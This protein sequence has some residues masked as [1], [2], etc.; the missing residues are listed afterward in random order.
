MKIG[1]DAGSKFIKACVLHSGDNIPELAYSEHYGNPDRAVEEI[2]EKYNNPEA[3]LFTGHFGEHLCSVFEG[4][5]YADEISSVLAALDY[6]GYSGKFI[7]NVGAA[8]IKSIQ[9]DAMG[10]FK[11]YTENTLCAAGTGSFVDEQMYRLGYEYTSIADIRPVENPPDIATRCAVFA[12]SDMIHCQQEGYNREE[13]WSGLCRGIV[14]TMLQ[15]VFKGD[16]PDGEVLFCGGLF[17][18]DVVKYWLRN[19]VPGARFSD[20]GHFLGAIGAVLLHERGAVQQKLPEKKE[21]S[22][23]AD[24]F[25]GKPLVAHRSRETDFSCIREYCAHGNE[26]R[27]HR[28]FA[29]AMKVA[30]GIDI[31]STSTKTVVID[32]ETGEVLA[33]IYRKTAGNPVSAAGALFDEL[34]DIFSGKNIEIVSSGTTGSGRRLIGEIIGAD[35]IVNEITAHFKGAGYF[36]S[37]IETIIEIGGQDSK[38]IRGRGGM[39]VDCNMN[40]VCAAGTGSFIEEQ[41][42]RLG[43]DVREV[44]DIVYGLT[45]PH[46][47]DRCTVFMEQDINKLLRDGYSREEALAAVIYSIARNYINRVVGSRPITGDRVSFMGATA[48]N[49]GLVAA[50]ENLLDREIVVSP[51]CHVMGAFGAALLSTQQTGVYSNR[52]AGMDVFKGAIRLEYD[53]CSKCANN[54]RITKAVFGDGRVESWGFLCGKE[55]IDEKRRGKSRSYFPAMK[56]LIHDTVSVAP[57]EGIA[58][59]RNLKKVG[60]PLVLSMHNYLPLWRTF[61]N[62]LGVEVVLSKESDGETKEKAVRISKTDFCFPMKIGL[63]HADELSRSEE[64]DA[65]FF[66]SFISEENQANGLPRVF[67]PYVISYPSV[68]KATGIKKPYIIPT[69]DFRQDEKFN[70]RELHESL[71]PYGFTPDDIRNAYRSAMEGHRNFLRKRYE[72]GQE[73]LS[74]MREEGKTGIVFIGRPYNLYDGIINLK[75]PDRFQFYDYVIFPHELLIDPDDSTEVYHMYWNYGEVILKNAELVRSIDN[76]YPVYLTNFSCGPDSFI[77]SR[78]EKIMAGKPYLIIELDEHGSETGYMT[79]IEA[80]NDIVMEKRRPAPDAD[81]TAQYFEAAWRN[82]G[83]KLW[84]PP[85]HEITG[86]LFAAGFRAWGYDAEALPVE[87]MEAFE[88]GKQKVRGSECLP[89]MTTVGAFLRMLRETGARPDEHALFMPTA[90]GPCRFGQYAVLHRS[91]LDREGYTETPIFSPSSVNSYMGMPNNLRLYL[92]ESML[93]SDTLMKAICAVRPYE[94]NQGETNAVA[95]ELIA[96]IISRIEK[97]EEL[98]PVTEHAV[99]RIFSIPR[100]DATRP[101]V[102]IVGEI[103]VRCNPFC[104]NRVIEAIERSG[105]EAWLSPI[106]EWILYTAWCEEYF[107]KLT[108]RNFL[109]RFIVKLKTGYLFKHAHR[110]EEMFMRYCPHRTEPA[111]EDILGD[112]MDFLPVHFEGEAILTAGRAVQFIKNGA[113][114]VVNCAPFGCMP[115]NISA[116]FFQQVQEQYKCPVVTIFYDGETDANRVVEVYLRNLC[117]KIMRREP[118]A[119]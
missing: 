90:E 50:F 12:K 107:N 21:V 110:F 30:V 17:L 34:R 96:D 48:R 58:K 89:A 49:R 88:L 101:L 100:V 16:V 28:E 79:R 37:D 40:F 76:L 18:N 94:V 27:I 70:I 65:I 36:Q 80:F 112:G 14:S 51:Y 82:K 72:K 56:H 103:Y 115:G 86:R 84:I 104:N 118:E 102:G 83:K 81:D 97:K 9:R 113:E 7:V 63:A 61:F 6:R 85:M 43:F 74:A 111:I 99:E 5:L 19:L 57:H 77:L 10:E 66:P 26:V 41:S 1:I 38:Y 33:D 52:F 15:T 109:N 47:S 20:D 46:A 4:S 62:H 29:D 32:Y 114:M 73:I 75:I 55:S 44:G 98:L 60:I 25:R 2:L 119:V 42:H 59:T 71:K 22:E 68:A 92:W 23:D 87:T 69:I 31:G 78:F 54:C 93:C 117:N 116:A 106:S 8:S 45:S 95:E 91:I 105:G 67:C 53:V 13:L 24:F 108:S 11:S 39:V 35:V 3:V 64:V